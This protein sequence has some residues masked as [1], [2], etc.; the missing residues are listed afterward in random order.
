MTFRLT[1][2]GIEFPDGT[3][4]TTRYDTTDDKGSLL[5]IDSWTSNGTYTW[6]R[7]TNCKQVRI[8]C[9]GGGGGASGH[10][11]GG[12]AGGYAEKWLDVT[13]ISSVTVT[14]GTGGSGAGYYS[15]REDG[16]TSSFGSYVS[17][18][19]GY[20]ANRNWQHSGGHGGLGH[21][22]DV[23]LRGGGGHGH[24]NEGGG[25]GSASYWGGGMLGA[26][27]QHHG[28]NAEN[29]VAPGAGG[30]GTWTSHGRGGYG[31]PGAVMVW[32]FA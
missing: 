30:M 23:N 24:E 3:T 31:K 25:A 32:N 10:C 16:G 26:H 2:T 14:V 12:G 4:Q 15:N 6:T 27:H 5:R 8:I 17:A 9:V 29:I 13:N 7:P 11:E 1:Q 18:G 22:G 21:G 20:G 19:G 28:T